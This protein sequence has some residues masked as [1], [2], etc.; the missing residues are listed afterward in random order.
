M[1]VLT[2]AELDV[3]DIH[4]SVPIPDDPPDRSGA[5]SHALCDF[6]G[7]WPPAGRNRP[8]DDVSLDGAH[9]IEEFL[10]SIPGSLPQLVRGLGRLICHPAQR[11]GSA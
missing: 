3:C 11:I 10:I 7:M 5:D 8:A 4:E 9:D 6:A 1:L 2:R